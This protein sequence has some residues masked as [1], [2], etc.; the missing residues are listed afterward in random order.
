MIKLYKKTKDGFKYWETW[1]ETRK[2]GIIHFGDVG[3]EGESKLIKSKLF[4]SYSKII[5]DEIKRIL[6][7]GYKELDDEDY[8]VLF[9]EFKIQG[10]GN[11]DDLEKRYRLQ[12]KMDELLGWNGLGHCDGGSIGSGTMEV[13]CFV[14]DYNIAKEFIAKEFIGTEFEDYS[15]IYKE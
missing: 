8:E 10:M 11:E 5:Q 4:Q 13:C 9:I 12:E 2:S 15:R 3:T 1:E 7:D 14:V 6:D